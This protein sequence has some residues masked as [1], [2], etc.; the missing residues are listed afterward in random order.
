MLT[1]KGYP[2]YT[3]VW[4][5]QPPL[6][7]VMLV[8]VIKL[9]GYQTGAARLLVLLLAAILVWACFQFLALADGRRT[10]VIGALLLLLL[11]Q[12]TQLSISVMVGLPAIALAMTAMLALA[13]WHTQ[14]K[15]LFLIVSAVLLSLSLLTKLFTGVLAPV[16]LIGLLAG[17]R[18][19]FRQNKN[20]LQLLAPALI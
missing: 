20:V 16:F 2:L 15:P 4:S 19:R 17:E 6:L 8:G 11:P 9:F 3:S 10:A 7:N 18:E 5:D 13:Y 1:E 12:F 14:R